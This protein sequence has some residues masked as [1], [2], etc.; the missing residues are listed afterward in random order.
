MRLWLG[1]AIA[2]GILGAVPAT[3]QL[4]TEEGDAGDLPGS[5][6]VPWG[7][8]PLATIAGAIGVNDVDMYCIRI[9]MTAVFIATTCGG[10]ALDTQLWLFQEDGLGVTHDD[11]DPSGCGLQSTITGQFITDPG[12]YFLAISVYNRDP[13]DEQAQLLWLNVPFNT[14]RAPDGQGAANPVARWSGDTDETGSY[15]I[16]LQGASYCSAEAVEPA[17][18]GGIK[19]M[20]R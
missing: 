10:S 20:Y 14:E 11:D 13:Y 18:W 7:V 9:D 2:L 5:A 1:M 6:Q 17:T 4:W 3:A 15:Q 12:R 16:A 19:S 8:G